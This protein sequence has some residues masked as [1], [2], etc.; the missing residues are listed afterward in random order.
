[1][2][3]Y[4]FKQG[5][6][7]T[8]WKRRWMSLSDD[9]IL[10][11]RVSLDKPRRGVIDLR[12]VIEIVRP[13]ECREREEWR[14]NSPKWPK[15]ALP[16]TEFALVTDKRTYFFQ[17]LTKQE[18]FHW[19][20]QLERVQFDIV[21]EAGSFNRK[22][23]ASISLE[24]TKYIIVK[25]ALPKD[26]EYGAKKALIG[27]SQSTSPSL[28]S[29]KLFVCGNCSFSSHPMLDT[30]S[31]QHTARARGEDAIS[32]VTVTHFVMHNSTDIASITFHNGNIS[33]EGINYGGK[34][35]VIFYDGNTIEMHLPGMR[36]YDIGGK[37]KDPRGPERI[38]KACAKMISRTTAVKIAAVLN[39]ADEE[40]LHAIHE[41]FDQIVEQY[42]GRLVLH[43]W[44]QHQ[45]VSVFVHH[46]QPFSYGEFVEKISKNSL[47]DAAPSLM[48]ANGV[49]LSRFMVDLSD[50]VFSHARKYLASR[51]HG[52]QVPS[53]YYKTQ[54]DEEPLEDIVSA[55]TLQQIERLSASQTDET[56]SGFNPV[57]ARLKGG[58]FIEYAL[59]FMET[60]AHVTDCEWTFLREEEREGESMCK[61]HVSVNE[62]GCRYD[63]E[64]VSTT[65]VNLSIIITT[66]PQ[67]LSPTIDT[68]LDSYGK[69]HDVLRVFSAELVASC[70]TVD[71]ICFPGVINLTSF[72]NK[73]KMKKMKQALTGKNSGDNDDDNVSDA[74]DDD[75]YNDTMM[76][77]H[78]I[79]LPGVRT[80]DPAGIEGDKQFGERLDDVGSE[81]I[82]SIIMCEVLAAMRGVTSSQLV[83]VHDA[84]SCIASHF[85]GRVGLH[86]W[87]HYQLLSALNNEEAKCYVDYLLEYEKGLLDLREGTHVDQYLETRSCGCAQQPLSFLIQCYKAENLGVVLPLK[88][89]QIIEDLCRKE[90]SSSSFSLQ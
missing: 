65:T 39:G 77:N 23:V 28:P 16:N 70:T 3:G 75:D 50:P 60:P 55:D 63:E 24:D 25:A 41:G 48:D 88:E 14:N 66:T 10:E 31:L 62:Y 4:A 80:Y 49:V 30:I 73:T 34:I 20:G 44:M 82:N 29:R 21:N 90:H 57:P 54:L 52:G 83:A 5:R 38:N 67:A 51:E 85:V 45:L 7:N 22:R 89:A 69:E 18:N 43:E 2:Q 36:T 86:N 42:H 79:L 56:F 6:I 12:E 1:M 71:A 81:F 64:D 26:Y 84:F 59:S 58:K 53:E 32:R 46:T 87:T 33:V 76:W 17:T 61:M 74:E 72:G 40:T 11:Y 19:I 47:D 68:I 15:V 27:F 13:T 35:C 8:A 9:G 78:Q 37:S